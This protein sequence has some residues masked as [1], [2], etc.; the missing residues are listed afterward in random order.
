M[1]LEVKLNRKPWTITWSLGIWRLTAGQ[2][3]CLSIGRQFKANPFG[4]TLNTIH[5]DLFSGATSI[6]SAGSNRSM[7]RASIK[8]DQSMGQVPSILLVLTHFKVANEAQG[9]A[10]CQLRV[11]SCCLPACL[12]VASCRLPV[13]SRQWSIDRSSRRLSGGGKDIISQAARQRP[14]AGSIELGSC[15]I[16]VRRRLHVATWKVYKWRVNTTRHDTARYDTT[17]RTRET[18]SIEIIVELPKVYHPSYN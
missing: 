9:S 18:L 10:S 16:Y 4:H 13:K 11:V 1:P 5:V 7:S 2:S 17:Q 8:R 3:I 15:L 14:L 12:S 6:D